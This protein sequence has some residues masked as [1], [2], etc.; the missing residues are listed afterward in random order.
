MSKVKTSTTVADKEAIDANAVLIA[1]LN[2]TIERLNSDIQSLRASQLDWIVRHDNALE[3][4]GRL[5]KERDELKIANSLTPGAILRRCG[6]RY[7]QLTATCPKVENSALK[8]SK[9]NLTTTEG[10]TKDISSL[11]AKDQEAAIYVCQ[12]S[13]AARR[14]AD[15]ASKWSEKATE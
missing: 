10:I 15:L 4:V 9:K 7:G 3:T 1:E 11:S 6:A 2:A 14:V 12:L 13:A 5:E 8:A